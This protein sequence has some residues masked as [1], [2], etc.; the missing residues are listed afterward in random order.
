LRLIGRIQVRTCTS[1]PSSV[2]HVRYTFCRYDQSTAVFTRPWYCTPSAHG[3]PRKIMT[4]LRPFVQQQRPLND[5]F[6]DECTAT[7]NYCYREHTVF[8]RPHTVR[9]GLLLF[10]FSILIDCVDSVDG[11]SALPCQYYPRANV[12]SPDDRSSCSVYGA[13]LNVFSDWI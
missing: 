12:P 1:V 7:D 5:W 10:S 11:L 13:L 4:S 3:I 2:K 6:H 9:D 8:R